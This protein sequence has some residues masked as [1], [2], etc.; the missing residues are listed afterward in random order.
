MTVV[1]QYLQLTIDQP[2]SWLV[3]AGEEY[4]ESADVANYQPTDRPGVFQLLLLL[5]S[6]CQARCC[7]LNW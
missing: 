5:P 3:R 7:H 6:A 2:N 1:Q 4:D